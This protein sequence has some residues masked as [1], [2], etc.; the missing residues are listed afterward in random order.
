M[1]V[2]ALGD[3]GA[4]GL[5]KGCA[6]DVHLGPGCVAGLGAESCVWGHFLFR[7]SRPSLGQ[8]RKIVTKIFCS[9]RPLSFDWTTLCQN[10]D[11]FQS[12]TPPRTET[13]FILQVA[14]RTKVSSGG[15]IFFE[16]IIPRTSS[17]S[18][19]P[20]FPNSNPLIHVSEVTKPVALD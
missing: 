12:R 13:F 15:G 2:V 19:Y 10:L 17:N 1:N 8:A 5:K 4:R 9:P 14:V 7:V 20:L 6:A 18:L 11:R 3:G 16:S